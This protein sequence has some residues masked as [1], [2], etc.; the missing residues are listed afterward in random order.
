MKYP[1]RT[2]IVYYCTYVALRYIYVDVGLLLY[3][4]AAPPTL[5]LRKNSNPRVIQILIKRMRK[6]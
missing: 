5:R 6:Q 4:I 2:P 1:C 3:V